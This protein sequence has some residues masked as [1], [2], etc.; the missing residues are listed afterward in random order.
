MTFLIDIPIIIHIFSMMINE[1]LL[2]LL[3]III[4]ANL[5]DDQPL[6][7]QGQKYTPSLHIVYGGKKRVS[8]CRC[9]P[10]L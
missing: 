10:I 1:P 5:H 4:Q 7:A 3:A 2:T 6:T 9:R 8:E